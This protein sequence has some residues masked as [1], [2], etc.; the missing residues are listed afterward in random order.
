MCST[1]DVVFRRKLST[2][3]HAGMMLFGPFRV[4]VTTGVVKRQVGFA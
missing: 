3:L 1:V 4:G 2:R